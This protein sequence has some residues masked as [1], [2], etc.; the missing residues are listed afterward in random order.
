MPSSVAAHNVSPADNCT[1]MLNP[2]SPS[3]EVREMVTGT[4][5]QGFDGVTHATGAIGVIALFGGGAKPQPGFVSVPVTRHGVKS[6]APATPLAPPAPGP[7]RLPHQLRS[8]LCA[9]SPPK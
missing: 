6:T 3:D 1:S 5:T 7:P 2:R 9:P 8:A 4:S